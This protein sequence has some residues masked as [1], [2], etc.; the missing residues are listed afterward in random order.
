MSTPDLPSVDPEWLALR[1]DAD[2]AA[3]SAELVHRLVAE[4]DPPANHPLVI[5]DLGCGTGA[6]MRWLAPLLPGPQH[7]VLC[8]RDATLLRHAAACVPTVTADGGTVTVETRVG[9][10]A[11]LDPRDLRS[12]GAVLVGASAL[13][14]LLTATELRQ[15]VTVVRSVGCAALFALS[16]VRR[17][18]LDPADERDAA[19]ASAF[20]AHQQR[21]VPGR[22]TLLGAAAPQ[23]LCTEFRRQGMVPY[24]AASPWR[25]GAGQPQ[26][27][28]QWLLGWIEAGCAWRPALEQSATDYLARRRQELARGTLRVTVP[29]IDVLAL[30]RSAEGRC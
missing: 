2:A 4:L 28:T 13:L 7:W 3:R 27:V 21:S 18:E 5:W 22:G 10:V 29:H 30:P 16:V 26:L 25:I 6:L 17:P 24:S 23:A 1:A 20:A 19:F 8:D 12:S 15:L 14:D 9:D 11:A